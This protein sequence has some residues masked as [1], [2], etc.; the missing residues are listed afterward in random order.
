[1]K[2]LFS[3]A[4]SVLVLSLA[5]IGQVTYVSPQTVTARNFLTAVGS[6]G[7]ISGCL[8]NLGQNVHNALYQVTGT[9]T[10]L[11]VRLE[12]SYNSDSATCT[13]GNWFSLSDDGSDVA[14]S[15]GSVV[16]VG[17]YPFLRVRVPVCGSCNGTTV[18]VSVS[19]TG[20]SAMPLY[21]TGFYNPSQQVRKIAFANVNQNTGAGASGSCIL[22][23]YG[24]TAGFILLTDSGAA[25]AGGSSLSVLAHTGGE[26]SSIN[27]NIIIPAT[28]DAGGIVFPLPSAPASCIDVSFTA[29]ANFNGN[30][31]AYVYFYPPGQ[32][33][34]YGAQPAFTLNS[35]TAGAPNTA[36]TVT[37]NRGSS[38]RLRSHLFTVNARCSAGT[39]QLTIQDSGNT[40]PFTLFSS[41]ATEVSTTSFFRQFHPGL[42]S[43]PGNNIVVNLSTCGV[44]NSGTVD[45]QGSVF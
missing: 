31:S 25:V 24:S 21:P 27:S 33:M 42:A 18:T 23:P 40:G 2:R 6:A 32:P 15:G 14:G 1:M 17:A 28:F 34:P 8:P 5:A 22:A 38:D 4:V 7:K 9:P 12:Y 16:G 29:G 37:I 41:A 45:V 10:S 39:A 11:D 26:S 30:V 3:L 19:Y 43:S 13:S 44:G 36:V 20:S 35:E